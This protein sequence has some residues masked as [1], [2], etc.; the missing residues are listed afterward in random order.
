M[1]DLGGVFMHVCVC[2]C[3]HV[4]ETVN[5]SVHMAVDHSKAVGIGLTL[6]E[7]KRYLSQMW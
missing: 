4:C 1:R 2:V 5:L 3:V 7:L 6:S